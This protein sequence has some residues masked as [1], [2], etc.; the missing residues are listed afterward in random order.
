MTRIFISH[1][2]SDQEIASLLVDFLLEA[3]KMEQE[4]IRCTSVIGHQLPFGTSIS[5]Q[6]RDDLNTTTGLI[7]LIT[8]DSLRSS[9]V[10]F[11]LGSA[12]ATR[13]LVVP[14]LGPGLNHQDLPGPLK[15]YPVVRI[16]D[17]QASYRLTD[18]IN[19]LAST[20]NVQ[21]R[22]SSKR[23]QRLNE[24][25]NE[26]R[27][28]S[29]PD[30]GQDNQLL[31]HDERFDI[32]E[33][34][35]KATQ[36]SQQHEIIKQWKDLHE[37]LQLL[38]VRLRGEFI[39]GIDGWSMSQDEDRYIHIR[40]IV[41]VKDVQLPS[42]WQYFR[43]K[44]SKSIDDFQ[45][46]IKII[47]KITE[48]M[49]T[50]EGGISQEWIDSKAVECRDQSSELVKAYSSVQEIIDDW[51]SDQSVN[52]NEVRSLLKRLNR[53]A[54]TIDNCLTVVDGN[55]KDQMSFFEKDIQSINQ[56]LKSS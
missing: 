27:S 1:S 16:D 17:E 8:K 28:Q 51:L 4:D 2:H 15:D 43:N 45:K 50:Q 44:I 38:S 13:R 23:D 18:A 3:L 30:E 19:K 40:K 46:I 24:F 26:F 39:K 11:E 41:N 6:L 55:L 9:W 12:W 54:T 35:N 52:D 32:N 25:L 34:R 56:M 36:I 14:I 31:N 20:L 29:S 48:S 49:A 7:A 10:L 47:P 22:I 53:L 21:Q 37:Q 5:E 33:C 42:G